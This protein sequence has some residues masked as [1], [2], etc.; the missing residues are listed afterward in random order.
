MEM[1][2]VQSSNINAIG[3][4]AN[5]GTMMIRFTNNKTY[6]YEGVKPE[7]F[8]AFAKSESKGRHFA[9][10]IRP[11]FTGT[12]HVEQEATENTSSPE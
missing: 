1:Q 5:T 12:V 9:A 2:T 3:F 4:D 6:K 8:E 10:M 11:K 7:E